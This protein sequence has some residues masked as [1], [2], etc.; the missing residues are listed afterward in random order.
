MMVWLKMKEFVWPRV[1]MGGGWMV[2]FLLGGDILGE[3]LP[4]G[5]GW[6]EGFRGPRDT[7]VLKN[8]IPSPVS[9]PAGFE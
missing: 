4:V 5:G 9:S 2:G 6:W 8:H 7:Y 3:D 1:A